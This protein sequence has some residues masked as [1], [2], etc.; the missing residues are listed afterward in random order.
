MADMFLAISAFLLATTLKDCSVMIT[1]SPT[2][3]AAMS[4]ERVTIVDVDPRSP[5]R[6]PKYLEQDQE[7]IR[8]Y[9]NC[10]AP[11]SCL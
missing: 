6:I 5:T 9:Q 10:C 4:N 7:L 1:L 11:S 3:T 8:E 2:T